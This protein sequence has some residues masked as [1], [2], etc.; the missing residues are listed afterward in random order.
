M[1]LTRKQQVFVNEYLKCWNATEAARKAGYSERSI[2]A[3][4][5]ENLTKP[6]IKAEITRRLEENAMGADEVLARLSD[7]ARAD[8]GKFLTWIDGYKE[9][10]IDISKTKDKTHLIKRMEY[11]KDGRVKFELHDAHAALRD[12]GKHHGLFTDNVE[13]SWRDKVPEGYTPDEVKQQ[14]VELMKLA[15]EKGA[16][17]D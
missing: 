8:V 10:I 6:Y 17:N 14:F 15:A 3:I 13:H 7:I 9:P 2:R 12:L 4:A 5:H 1:G 11:D 16:G